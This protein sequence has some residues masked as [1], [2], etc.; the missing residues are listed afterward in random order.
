VWHSAERNSNNCGVTSIIN[1]QL[2]LHK[3]HIKHLKTIKMILIFLSVFMWNLFKWNCWLI[4]EMILRNAR[5]N[6]KVYKC[7]VICINDI[8]II[9]RR[10]KVWI[11]MSYHLLKHKLFVAISTVICFVKFFLYDEACYSN[12][13]VTKAAGIKQKYEHTERWKETK[14][15]NVSND[16]LH[17][18]KT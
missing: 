12:S 7:G 13:T 9:I 8:I 4:I 14:G 16:R 15:R 6:N 17:T 5:C 2:H 3:F 18:Y 1:Q 10:M 11:L